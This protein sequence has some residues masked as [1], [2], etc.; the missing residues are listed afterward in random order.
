MRAAAYGGIRGARVCPLC[1]KKTLFGVSVCV[2]LPTC[3]NGGDD[4]EILSVH[5]DRCTKCRK[6]SFRGRPWDRASQIEALEYE[7]R[8]EES[9]AKTSLMM[10]ERLRTMASAL[11]KLIPGG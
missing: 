2:G 3:G 6:H 5:A 9:F 8:G 10:A 11:R 1:G 4:D 7:A